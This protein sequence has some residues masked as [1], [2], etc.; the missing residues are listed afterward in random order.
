MDSMNEA[1]LRELAIKILELPR[2][3]RR[4]EEFQILRRLIANI[5]F[6]K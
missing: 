1:E 4:N 3:N 5:E 2:N 6:F